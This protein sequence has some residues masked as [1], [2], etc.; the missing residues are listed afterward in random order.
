MKTLIRSALVAL[1]APVLAQSPTEAA[2]QALDDALML[3]YARSPVWMEKYIEHP[4]MAGDLPDESPEAYAEYRERQA[5]LLARVEGLAREGLDEDTLLTVDL[6]RYQLALDLEAADLF[7]EQMPVNSIGGPQYWLPQ[8]ESFSKLL[9]ERDRE[10]YL[11]RLA[12]VPRTL[13]QSI[14]QMRA[15]I[16]AGRVAPRPSVEPAVAQARAQAVESAERSPFFKPFLAR[17]AGDPQAERARAIILQQIAPAYAA[18]ADFLEREYLPACRE[19]VGI[20]QSIDGVR[21]YEIALREHTTLPLTADEVHDIGLREVARIR[22]EMHET[23]KRTDWYASTGSAIADDDGRFRAFTEF[24]RTD[25][26]FYFT[27]EDELLDAYRAAAKRID[28]ELVRLFGRLPRLPYGIRPIPPFAAKFSPTAYYYAGAID[29]GRPGYFMANTSELSQR[30]RYDIIALTLHEAMPGHHLENALNDELEGVHPVRRATGFTAFGE[31]WGL[32]SERLGL[33]MGDDPERGLYADPYDDFGR[34]NFEIWRAIRLVVDSGLH[35]KGWSRQR[36]IDYMRDNSGATERNIV[37][38]IDRYIG[39]PGQA[40]AY[41]IGELKIREL[42]A[43][44]EQRL[45]A[46]FDVRAFHDHLL[47]AGSLPLP[48][49]EERM[50]RWVRDW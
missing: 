11:S 30:P 46:R 23:I 16:T 22:A 7:R 19:T 21:A 18:F 36:A 28:P 31:G 6:V 33:E 17:P 40:T 37:N 45:G 38:E 26:R 32:Y 34:L 25:P 5:E 1:A 29:E 39:W 44:A 27:T 9:T 4:T 15:G 43:M 14:V 48:V 50:K 42:R 8:L 10:N 35:A 3:A 41:K 49:L 24:L 13:E 2:E 47:G 12:Q 20:S